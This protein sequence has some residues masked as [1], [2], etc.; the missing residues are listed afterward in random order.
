MHKII[1]IMPPKDW[2]YGIDYLDSE[3]MIKYFRDNEIFDVY[4]FE[5]IEIFLK[6]KL[7]FKDLIKIIYIYFFF[8]IKKPQY[9]FAI[10]ASYIA[11]CNLV[12]KKKIINFFS[13]ILGIKCVMRWD[14]INEQ[15]PNI[16]ERILDKS[17][18]ENM[19]DYKNF[20]L[21]KINNKKFLHYTWQNDEYFSKKDYLIN[22]LQLKD[23]KLKKL[24]W[25]FTFNIKKNDCSFE[26]ANINQNI[27]LIGYMNDPLEPKIDFDKISLVLK[28]RRNH[29]NKEYY[30]EFINYSN[31]EYSR[32]KIEL[33]EIK[34]IQF[35]GI[36]PSKNHGKVINP[37]DFFSEVS[38]FFMIINPTN[39]ISLTI[40]A[41][42]YLI[43]LYGGFCIHELPPEIPPKLNKFKEFIFYKDQT[44]L[45]EKIE[46]LKN[47]LSVY[48]SIKKEINEISKNLMVDTYKVFND[49]F[50][51]K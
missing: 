43:Y 31:Y 37:N 48:K 12:F 36:N 22:T 8:K 3:R 24:N 5:N 38:K 46:Y 10:N 35:Y 21:D 41:K 23:L 14:H 26:K 4:K 29:F 25:Y 28:D 13:Q 39:P 40:T 47:N 42:F 11:Y 45:I 16:V 1:F 27:A 18:F 32:K 44:D 34:N 30:K 15:I 9:V 51:K 17:K 33:L 19:H 2:F 50:I 7:K 6:S 49:E 20:F